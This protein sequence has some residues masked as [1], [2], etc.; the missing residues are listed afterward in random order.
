M[1]IPECCLLYTSE[2]RRVCGFAPGMKYDLMAGYIGA[3]QPGYKEQV[4]KEIAELGRLYKD[5]KIYLMYQEKDVYKRQAKN[6]LGLFYIRR[7]E[8]GGYV[9]KK[10][11]GN[12]LLVK[13]LKEEGVDTLF[14]YPGACTIDISDELYKQD[15]TK[16]ILP[17][18]EVALV[19]EA[20]C[21]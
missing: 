17:R 7:T 20:R 5:Y 16:V 14:G 19:H 8:T 1:I 12:K 6:S 2:L 4:E 21:V 10:I 15:Y 9:M 11:S 18:Q 3:A 13:A